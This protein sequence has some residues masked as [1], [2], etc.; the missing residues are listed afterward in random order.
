[1][2]EPINEQQLKEKRQEIIDGIAG[3]Y[4]LE[5]R[6]VCQLTKQAEITWKARDREVEVARQAGA[7]GVV[8]L[9]RDRLNTITCMDNYADQDKAITSLIYE[10]RKWGIGPKPS[11]VVGDSQL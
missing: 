1:M 11:N 10:L 5:Y 3:F 6:E 9:V 7:R 8:G 4:W 2:S